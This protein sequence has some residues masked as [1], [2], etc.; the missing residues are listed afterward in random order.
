MNNPAPILDVRFSGGHRQRLA[1][2]GIG[3]IPLF[4]ASWYRFGAVREI[5][6]GPVSKDLLGERLVAFQSHDGCISVMDA[7]CSHMHA[8]LGNGRV[9]NGCIE[10][11]FHQWKYGTDG[12]CIDIP[13]SDHVPAFAQQI[14][15]PAQV[16][17]GQIY[18]FNGPKPLFD[19][20]FYFDEAPQQFAYSRIALEIVEA[21]WYMIS[22]NSVDMQHFRIAH[23]RTLMS[24]PII[25]HP[26]PMAHRATLQ[27]QIIGNSWSDRLTR[28]VGGPT[29][30]LEVTEWAGTV[31]LARSTLPRV[32]T[33]GMLFMEPLHAN[34]TLVH[35]MVLARKSGNAFGRMILDPIRT[36][37]RAKLIRRFLRSDIPRLKG[38]YVHPLTLLSQDQ[39]IVD[40]LQLLCRLPC[41]GPT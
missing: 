5:A 13:C 8:D 39:A 6:R 28:L 32:Q 11:P 36:S 22:I 17:H 3:S 20:P 4:P 7:R 1:I 10:C 19:L 33:F 38:S 24:E 35:I 41:G 40:Y 27:F 26:D 29:V 30:Q 23:D 34:R 15:Y 25:D 9:V 18:F 21:P 37:I 2:P 16:R 12:R 31:V 14:V